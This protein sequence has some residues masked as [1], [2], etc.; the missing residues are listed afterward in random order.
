MEEKKRI[1]VADDEEDIREFLKQVLEESGYAV[2]L[3]CDGEEALAMVSQGKFDLITLD[4]QM[5][6]K[7]GLLTLSELK[8][9]PTASE[10][11]VIMMTGIKDKAGVA[12]T[13][14]GIGNAL[15]AEPDVYLEKPVSQRELLRAV[16][17]L[18]QS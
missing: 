8:A 6:K 2:T 12:L 1:L 11:P 18:L 15:G 4:V 7:D 5:P 14:E 17:S 9:L 3:A 10:I 16:E 13:K